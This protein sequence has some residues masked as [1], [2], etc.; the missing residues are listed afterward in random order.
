[1]NINTFAEKGL[2]R[3]SNGKVWL[4][5]GDNIE[6]TVWVCL[7]VHDGGVDPLLDAIAEAA[8]GSIV[9][10]MNIKWRIVGPDVVFF[11]G[12]VDTSCM[13]EDEMPVLMDMNDVSALKEML[14]A[15]YHLSEEEARH[16]VENRE[17]I[18]ADLMLGE[19][20]NQLS[21]G[22]VISGPA[23]PSTCNY[24]SVSIDGWELATLSG[25]DFSQDAELACGAL[26]GAARGP[27]VETIGG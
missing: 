27:I 3:F 15:Q 14:K 9:G 17:L 20:V 10:L 19:C 1:M 22:R 5:D 16:A 13:E 25:D 26:L 24:I 11:S 23:Y 7:D 21:N 6:G 18:L 12:Q 2:Y 8:T 4:M